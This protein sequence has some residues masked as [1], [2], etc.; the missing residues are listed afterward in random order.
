MYCQHC[1]TELNDA[2]K[3][4]DKCGEQTMTISGSEGVMQVNT[5]SPREPQN[6]TRRFTPNIN[7]RGLNWFQRH[8]NWTW[9][10]VAI[11][12]SLVISPIIAIVAYTSVVSNSSALY[13]VLLPLSLVV[14]ILGISGWVLYRKN[15]HVL[16]LIILFI[17]FGWLFFLLLENRRQES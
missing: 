7:Y 5:S 6:Q 3:F 12:G 15:R 11:L 9:I 13:S 2:S 8:L 16:W 4:C 10:L 1:G 17:P 14:M